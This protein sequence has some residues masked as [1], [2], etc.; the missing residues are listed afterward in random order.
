M[1][2][3]KQAACIG[4]LLGSVVLGGCGSESNDGPPDIRYGD[5]VCTECGMIISDERFA[6]ATVVDGDRGKENLVFDDFSCQMNFEAKHD[7]IVIVDRWAHDHGSLQ[8]I[9]M[10]DAWFVQ[11]D[12]LLT[13]MASH[14]ASFAS[15]EDAAAF[16]EPI[17]GD[18]KDF[19][20]LWFPE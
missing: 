15:Q 14:I 16:A 18:T 1:I 12:Q 10:A 3:F 6:S 7:E 8:W 2:P 17:D 13:P 11:S 5:S 19:Q 9:H 4:V 20:S